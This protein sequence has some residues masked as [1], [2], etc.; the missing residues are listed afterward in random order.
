[1]IGA[2]HWFAGGGRIIIQNGRL[3]QLTYRQIKLSRQKQ[4]QWIFTLNHLS[5]VLWKSKNWVQFLIHN[6]K[7]ILFFLNF[8]SISSHLIDVSH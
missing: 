2:A 4:I 8:N 3:L 6:L 7:M 1:M 5:N